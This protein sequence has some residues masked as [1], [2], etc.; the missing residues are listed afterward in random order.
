MKMYSLLAYVSYGFNSEALLPNGNNIDR[1]NQMV[2]KMDRSLEPGQHPVNGFRI[3]AKQMLV[4]ATFSVGL[5]QSLT[6]KAI[7]PWGQNMP[8]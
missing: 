7:S 1:N 5:H 6:F 3:V 2:S 4:V 8:H